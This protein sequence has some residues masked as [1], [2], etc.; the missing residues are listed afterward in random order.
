[1]TEGAG[2]YVHLPY[3]RSRCGYCAFVVSTDDSTAGAYWKA[4][5]REMELVLPEASGAKF[6]TI[7]LGGGTPSLTP[8][9]ELEHLL[10]GL[11]SS[12]DVSPPCCSITSKR[13]AVVSRWFRFCAARLAPASNP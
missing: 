11:R 3:C 8:A 13:C 6:D 10:D 12:F 7:Y 9:G 4:I 2:L 1:M 5:D